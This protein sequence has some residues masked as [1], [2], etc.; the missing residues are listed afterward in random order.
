MTIQI[1]MS[2]AI[3]VNCHVSV[4]QDLTGTS[5]TLR[6]EFRA[7]YESFVVQDFLVEPGRAQ[8]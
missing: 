4:Y 8:F 5:L 2:T 7:Y 1:N 6:N 3:H